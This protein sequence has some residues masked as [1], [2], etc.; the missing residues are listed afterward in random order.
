M[1]CSI[2][3]HKLFTTSYWILPWRQLYPDF[4]TENGTNQLF[5]P[6]R[7]SIILIQPIQYFTDIVSTCFER[8]QVHKEGMRRECH[9]LPGLHSHADSVTLQPLPVREMKIQISIEK[10]LHKWREE[11]TRPSCCNTGSQMHSNAKKY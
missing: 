9:E 8:S 10:V 3:A 1:H 6:P 4:W 2:S 11:Y 5:S 7:Q